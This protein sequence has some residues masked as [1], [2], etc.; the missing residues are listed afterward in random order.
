MSTSSI[1]MAAP[2]IT[3]IRFANNRYQAE[4]HLNGWKGYWVAG[5]RSG[6]PVKSFV[7]G[8]FRPRRGLKEGELVS[9]TYR[10]DN[11]EDI[12]FRWYAKSNTSLDEMNFVVSIDGMSGWQP[13]AG[14]IGAQFY[15]C[16]TL[17]QCRFYPIKI[18]R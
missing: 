14:A 1:I 15:E 9:L 4:T 13:E 16:T 5:D 3:E 8:L 17:S 7:N 12:D 18:D 6:S 10:L 2:T 11:G